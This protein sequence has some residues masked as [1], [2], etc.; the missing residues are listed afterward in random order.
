MHL[1]ELEHKQVQDL[2]ACDDDWQEAY[3]QLMEVWNSRQAGLR[4]QLQEAEQQL[5]QRQEQEAAALQVKYLNKL[6]PMSTL[7][8]CLLT[9]LWP[10]LAGA[11]L[12]PGC[13]C[14]DPVTCLPDSPA[15][16]LAR[17]HCN[18]SGQL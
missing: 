18:H 6:A 15:A 14:S 3:Q 8:L 5:L 9:I 1:Q 13:C 11:G 2:Y 10:V 4:L 12:P 7:H 16:N 17:Q